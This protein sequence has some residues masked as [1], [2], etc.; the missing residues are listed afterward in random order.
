MAASDKGIV[1]EFLIWVEQ[2]MD[3]TADKAKRAKALT[4]EDT[5]SQRKAGSGV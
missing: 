2:K 3:Q 5:Q 1:C 4:I